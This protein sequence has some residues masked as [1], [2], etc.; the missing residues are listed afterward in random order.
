MTHAITS[1]EE[2][3]R[4]WLDDL[5]VSH[6]PSGSPVGTPTSTTGKKDPSSGIVLAVTHDECLRAML[7][8][9]TGRQQPKDDG[10][11]PSSPIDVGI[12]GDVDTSLAF[13]NTS[14]AIVRVWWEQ[15]IDGPNLIPRGRMEAWAVD[16]HLD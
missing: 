8:V 9:L 14:L 12:P 13:G 5:L 4:A 3:L 6:T 15:S 2:R 16:D 11:P 10:Q 1:I 7:S